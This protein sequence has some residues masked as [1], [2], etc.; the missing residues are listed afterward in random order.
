MEDSLRNKNKLA[1]EECF[2]GQLVTFTKYDDLSKVTGTVL[3]SLSCEDGSR[4]QTIV[5]SEEFVFVFNHV[6]TDLF[7]FVR[8]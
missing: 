4:L 2:V 3:E 7:M 8:H 6:S 5:K 1:F